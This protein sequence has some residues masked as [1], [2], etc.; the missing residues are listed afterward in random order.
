MRS[1][2]YPITARIDSLAASAAS[3]IA[4]NCASCVM[5]PG[6]M[7]MIHRAWGLAIGNCVDLRK[8]SD[9]LEKIDGEIAAAY[10]GRA[11]ADAEVDA[12]LAR[13][14]AE[15]WY[16]ASEAVEAGLA[17]AVLEENT[18]RTSNRWDL[19]A[20]AAVPAAVKAELERAEQEA[21]AA[22]EQAR[23]E[24]AEADRTIRAHRLQARL[25]ATP[26]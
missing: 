5:V 17:D 7:Q 12:W 10:A 23:R 22:E 24:A 16:T 21:R 14:D 2:A 19:S 26:I 18:Q 3:V 25:L 8:T 4:A 15:T 20:F 11:K 1:H 6:S 9:L 13:M